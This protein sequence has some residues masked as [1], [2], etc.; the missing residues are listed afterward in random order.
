MPGPSCVTTPTSPT[1]IK[2]KLGIGPQVDAP[3]DLTVAE[4]LRPID[5]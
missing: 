4:A 5:L 3:I 2:E 1:R